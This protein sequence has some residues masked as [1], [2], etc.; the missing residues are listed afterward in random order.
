MSEVLNH[1]CGTCGENHPHLLNIYALGVGIA[2]CFT[3][4]KSI[5]KSKIQ[6]WKRK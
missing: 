3:Y 5:I 6:L 1:L 2:G 4:I